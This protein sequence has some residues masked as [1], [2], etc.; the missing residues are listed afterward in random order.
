[1]RQNLKPNTQAVPRWA[2]QC[3]KRL[4]L[5]CDRPGAPT[6]SLDFYAGSFFL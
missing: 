3:G 5:E 6:F 1:M 2:A 4:Y